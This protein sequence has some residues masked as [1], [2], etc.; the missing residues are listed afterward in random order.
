VTGHGRDLVAS[1]DL[2]MAIASSDTAKSG[3]IAAELAWTARRQVPVPY[4]EV[5]DCD[6]AQLPDR[7]PAGPWLILESTDST[8]NFGH[9][10]KLLSEEERNAARLVEAAQNAQADRPVDRFPIDHAWILAVPKSV[11]DF[12]FRDAEPSCMKAWATQL[13]LGLCLY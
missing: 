11:A 8:I 12:V 13:S 7:T 2:A 6:S 3:G 4:V 5:G 10:K 1:A 9:K